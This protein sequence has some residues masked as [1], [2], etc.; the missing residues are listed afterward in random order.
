MKEKKE[1]NVM[2]EKDK[3]ERNFGSATCGACWILF[4][5]CPAPHLNSTKSSSAEYRVPQI[6]FW[7][8]WS[9]PSASPKFQCTAPPIDTDWGELPRLLLWQS[10]NSA[11]GGV[12][13]D[14]Q[15]NRYTTAQWY[16]RTGAGLPHL[17]SGFPATQLTLSS[18]LPVPSPHFPLTII[19]ISYIST[20]LFKLNAL[21]F[22]HKPNLVL[23]ASG[24]SFLL[25]CSHLGIF[26]QQ[27]FFRIEP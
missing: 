4:Q 5:C 13:W 6:H 15:V 14:S 12:V 3:K 9:D 10:N 8:Y 1:T 7:V 21:Q 24:Q 26:L 25:V 22:S 16:Q 27:A 2:K 20:W 19:Q 17:P 23:E 11:R 18:S